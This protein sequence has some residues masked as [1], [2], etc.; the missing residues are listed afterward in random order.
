LLWVPFRRNGAELA[1][2]LIDFRTWQ[3]GTLLSR[4]IPYEDFLHLIQSRRSVR[5]FSQRSVDAALVEQVLEAA[6][7]APSAGNR[8]AFRFIVVTCSDTI[9]ALADRVRKVTVEMSAKAREDVTLDY[10]AYL[11]NFEHFANA[12]VLIVPIYRGGLDLLAAGQTGSAVKENSNRPLLDALSSV[13]A[14]IM[15]LLLAAHAIGLASC[16]MTG[17]LVAS[18]ALAEEL[19]VPEGWQIAAILPLGYADEE[20]VAPPR[21]G[22]NKLLRFVSA[23]GSV[24][25]KG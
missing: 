19:K 20:P 10:S 13:S 17:P 9:G 22:L 1:A 2:H 21:R 7:W 23:D 11:K 12:P 25:E 24:S 5:R 6:R 16:W 3:M 14:A 15:N 4:A 8:Q 18:R